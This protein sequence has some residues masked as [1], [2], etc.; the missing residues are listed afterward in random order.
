MRMGVL[1]G[2]S[3][4]CIIERSC[5]RYGDWRLYIIPP[6]ARS[7][8][9]ATRAIR[10]IATERPQG[11]LHSA[12]DDDGT[13]SSIHLRKFREICIYLRLEGVVRRYSRLDLM[14]ALRVLGLQLD[15]FNSGG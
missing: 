4:L 14:T 13:P 6:P 8:Y 11:P 5:P 12:L 7:R 15:I 10:P 2:V 9:S 1:G 3:M